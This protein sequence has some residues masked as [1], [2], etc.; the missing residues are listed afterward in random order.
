MHSIYTSAASIELRGDTMSKINQAVALSVA[1][2]FMTSA[3]MAAVKPTP[4]PAPIPSQIVA[5][6]KIF[7]AN[8]GGD[9]MAEDD[10]IFSGGPDRAYN[11]FYAAIKGWGRFEVVGSPREADLLLEIRQEVQTVSLGGKAGA[12]D[13]PLFR[14]I[15]RDPKTNTLLWGFHVHSTFGVGQGNSDRNFDEAVDRLVSDL[16][17][18][19]SPPP[20]AAAGA[21][22]P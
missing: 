19:V 9:E 20:N 4:A 7:I 6:K 10:P 16:R 2:V 17:G 15:I 8:A 11:Q 22:T 3:T 13:T 18:L 5:A 12:S 14:L 1:V 21:G